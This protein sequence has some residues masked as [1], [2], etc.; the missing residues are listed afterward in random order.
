MNYQ[1]IYESLIENARHRTLNGYA[2]RHHVIPKCIG[3]S[4]DKDNLVNLTPE[5]HYVAHQLLVKIYPTNKKL[6]HAAVMMIPNRP[7]NKMYGWLRRKLAKTI[8]ENQTGLGN[9]QYGTTWIFHE[10]FGSK[11]I[12]KKNLVAYIDQGWYKGRIIKY[13]KS[14]NPTKFSQKR[15]SDI[16]LYKMYYDVYSKH[17]FKK[18]VEI[19]GY[20]H[21][22]QNL[23]QRFKKLV[24]EFVPQNGKK[25]G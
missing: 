3:G 13:Q 9:S 10:M 19:T 24:P 4:D 1:K 14:K 23:V 5:E 15:S 12:D 25:R 17:G 6:I 11:K 22:K 2:E 21:S 18:F 8:S 20:K 16:D 7:S